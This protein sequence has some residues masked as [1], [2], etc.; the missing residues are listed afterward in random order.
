MQPMDVIR[1]TR[2]KQSFATRRVPLG[3]IAR[4]DTAAERLVAGDLVLARVDELG[5]HTNVER[6]DGRRAKLFPGDEILIACG[7]RYAPDQFEAQCPAALGP[8]H[9]AAAG[10]IAGLVDASH[11]R[12]KPPTAIT[13]LGAVCAAS[14]Q[15]MNLADFAVAAAPRPAR[16]PVLAV[17][18]TSMNSGKTHTVASIVRGLTLGGHRAAA[19]KVTGTGSGGDLWL[20]RDAGAHFV[21]D[22]T[23]AGFGTT[24]RAPVEAIIEGARRLIAAAEDA[25]A[26]AIVIEIADGLWQDETAA[27]LASAPFRAMLGGMVFAANDAMG[28]EAGVARLTAMGHRVCAISGLLTRSPL[29]MREAVLALDLPCLTAAELSDS[30]TLARLVGPALLPGAERLPS[31][32]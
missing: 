28:A 2:V 15:R 23:D 29:A 9:L 31:A 32:A 5:H 10:G 18:G 27:L 14:G 22:F 26:E 8:A 19:L 17:C 12:M 30:A 24:Y 21:A 1:L 11:D 3:D 4:I 13:L 7:A 16:V 6:P 20:F 25:G